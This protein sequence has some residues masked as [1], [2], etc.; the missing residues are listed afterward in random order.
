MALRRLLLN[1]LYLS[2]FAFPLYLIRFQVAGIPFSLLEVFAYL[3]FA[4]WMTEILLGK[5]RFS[6]PPLDF[7]QGRAW[8]RDYWLA[9]LLLLAGVS[10][11]AL[12]APDSLAL[13]SGELLNPQRAAWGVWKGWVL[14][15]LL[16][17]AVLTQTLRTPAQADR[18]LRLFVFS[19]ALVGL[20]AYAFGLF[21]E[22]FAYDFRLKGFYDSPN[23]LS[24]SL[25]PP[26]LLGVY[27]AFRRSSRS[28]WNLLNAAALAIMAHALA[29]TQSYGAILGV[30]GALGLYVLALGFRHAKFRKPALLAL[31]GLAAFF[32]LALA[33][34]WD[35]PKFRQALDLEGQSSSSVRVEIYQVAL[36]LAQESPFSGIGPGLF[37]AR[38]QS[39]APDILSHAPMEWA[40]PHP[41]NLYL[42]FWLN[43]GILGLL[44]F[45]VLLVLAHARFTYPLI[46]LW[47]ILIHGLFDTPF[48]KGDLAMAFWLVLAAIFVLQAAGMA[49]GGAKKPAA[50]RQ[51]KIARKT[52]LKKSP[53]Q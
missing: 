6:A 33:S 50:L 49:E 40:V 12:L 31:L 17:F 28:A 15:P 39:S 19:G 29:L 10:V 35:S 25:G 37:Q 20:A 5:E 32:A 26:L 18:L 8:L 38:Y 1:L 53:R 4:L 21:G 42:A 51:R 44:G 7:A 23:H 47:G 36:S 34:Q 41:H 2:P 46:A 14:A 9:A 30:F 52:P 22:G 45:L 3:L 27:F 11:G 48:W 16:Y 13:P 24:L 43:A